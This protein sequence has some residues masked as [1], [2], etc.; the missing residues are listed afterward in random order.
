MRLKN[1]LLDILGTM[2]DFAVLE[3]HTKKSRTRAE[4]HRHDLIA[5]A[6]RY[7]DLSKFFANFRHSLKP[8]C[9]RRLHALEIK[10]GHLNTFVDV[11]DS[12][13]VTTQWSVGIKSHANPRPLGE[14]VN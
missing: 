6:S 3:L 8:S 2:S 12:R 5:I 7:P 4:S 13:N 9:N 11:T 10:F 14:T 1:G